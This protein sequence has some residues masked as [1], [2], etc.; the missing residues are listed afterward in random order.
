[1]KMAPSTV[2]QSLAE[3]IRNDTGVAQKRVASPLKSGHSK[4]YFTIKTS[5]LKASFRYRFGPYRKHRGSGDCAGRQYHRLRRSQRYG[6]LHLRQ[7]VINELSTKPGSIISMSWSRCESE[8]SSTDAQNMDT[9]LKDA[10]IY[11][12][13]MFANTGDYGSGCSHDSKAFPFGRRDSSTVAA[14]ARQPVSQTQT[15]MRIDDF[16]KTISS[17]WRDARAPHRR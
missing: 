14:V 4:A 5:D 8:I 12:I 6:R 2:T 9:L 16:L 10:S 15:R 7:C 1:L 17:A 3:L 11:S 13:T